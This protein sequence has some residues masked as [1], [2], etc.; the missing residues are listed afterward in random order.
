MSS[1]SFPTPKPDELVGAATDPAEPLPRPAASSRILDEV[2]GD[3][4]P[5]V[6]TDEQPD[7]GDRSDQESEREDWYREN[8]PPHHG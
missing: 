7:L 5:R 3:V 4:V 6:S 8:T 2:F 1:N